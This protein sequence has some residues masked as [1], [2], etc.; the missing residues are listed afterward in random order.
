MKYDLPF[1]KDKVRNA[2]ICLIQGDSFLL[3]A[4]T[5][6]RT[7]THKFGEYL[8]KEFPGWH[9]DCEYNRHGDEVKKIRL[10]DDKP[11]YDDTDGRTVFPDIIVHL[12]NTDENLLVIEAKK[13]TSRVKKDF[14][15]EKLKA[16]TLP[17]YS[18]RFGLFVMFHTDK[19]QVEF[20]TLEWYMD[21]RKIDE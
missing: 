2:I 9:V 19:E 5:N 18:Y 12:R 20:P 3:T 1:V 13:S 7:I 11:Q 14:D 17:P 16:F 21:G 6:E 8:Q 4:D 10:P 15:E